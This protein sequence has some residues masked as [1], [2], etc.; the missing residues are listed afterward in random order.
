ML[1]VN[2]QY[3]ERMW[4]GSSESSQAQRVELE[5]S[6]HPGSHPPTLLFLS[7]FLQLLCFPR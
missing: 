2:A 7:M 6:I 4:L 3:L 1:I 5:R